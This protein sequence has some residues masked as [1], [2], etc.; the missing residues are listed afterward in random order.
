[1]PDLFDTVPD[2]S[3]TW[4]LFEQFT[5][6]AL[7]AG[8][9]R[10]G[11]KMIAERIRWETMLRKSGEYKFNNNLTAE[12]ARRFMAKYPQFDGIF[13]TRERRAE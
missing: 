6:E 11:A 8:R 4:D 10:I 7:N 3:A 9:R 1:M 13:E 12:Y 2:D 5:F